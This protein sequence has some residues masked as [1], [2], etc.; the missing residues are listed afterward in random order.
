MIPGFSHF[1]LFVILSK[2]FSIKKPRFSIGSCN[3][4]LWASASIKRDMARVSFDV[5]MKS[6][7]NHS[8]STRLFPL[9]DT[10]RCTLIWVTHDKSQSPINDHLNAS[11]FHV[12]MAWNNILMTAITLFRTINDNNIYIHPIYLVEHDINYGIL[13]NLYSRV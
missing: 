7:C 1:S 2:H 10:L 6:A 13:N 11:I 8:Q 5:E 3:E 12:S 9:R 4:V